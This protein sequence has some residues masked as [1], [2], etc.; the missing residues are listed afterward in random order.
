MRTGRYEEL[1]PAEKLDIKRQLLGALYKVPKFREKT[2]GAMSLGLCYAL[3]SV[4]DDDPQPKESRKIRQ[5]FH[6]LIMSWPK[7]TKN[8]NYPIYLKQYARFF[9]GAEK[10]YDTRAEI[11]EVDADIE[12]KLPEFY[13]AFDAAREE[14]LDWCITTLEKELEP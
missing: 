8:E 9:G 12:K 14:L 13:S 6:G 3:T 4:L 10:Q 1:S 11:R 5:C 2:F 7:A